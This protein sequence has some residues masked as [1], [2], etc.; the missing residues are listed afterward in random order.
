MS[1]QRTLV[2]FALTVFA[3]GGA[4][5]QEQP[6]TQEQPQAQDLPPA[7]EPPPLPPKVQSGEPLEPDVT[8]IRKEQE[9]VREY[10]V[11]GRLYAVKVQP[12]NGPAYYLV[13][14]DGDGNLET[15]RNELAPGFLVPSWVIFRW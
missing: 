8:I 4:W 1:I 15:R 11:N 14:A 12:R 6:Q 2:V 9:T 5:A 7:A 3:A 13:D 10:R